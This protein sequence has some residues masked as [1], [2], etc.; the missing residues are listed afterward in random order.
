[1]RNDDTCSQQLPTWTPGPPR[2]RQGPWYPCRDPL[3]RFDP[4]ALQ[5]SIHFMQ[6]SLYS[7]GPTLAYVPGK[8]PCLK[9]PPE[10]LTNLTLDI[11]VFRKGVKDSSMDWQ[12]KLELS[13]DESKAVQP[14][15][16]QTTPCAAPRPWP[17]IAG[18]TRLSR[19][20]AT[21]ASPTQ[22]ISV[23][24]HSIQWELTDHDSKAVQARA[25]HAIQ[26]NDPRCILAVAKHPWSDPVAQARAEVNQHNGTQIPTWP[27]RIVE[28]DSS[29]PHWTACHAGSPCPGVSRPRTLGVLHG[30]RGFRP[31]DVATV[32]TAIPVNSIEARTCTYNDETGSQLLPTW[33]KGPPRC[34][35]GSWYP[36][37]GPMWGFDPC[38][39]QSGIPFTQVS[40][41]ASAPTL[42]YGPGKYSSLKMPPETSSDLTFNV[43]TIPTNDQRC[44]LA[45]ARHRWSDPAVQ[46]SA[47]VSQPNDTQTRT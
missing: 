40:L 27:S 2:Y 8:Y 21:S 34:I 29:Q 28:T 38:A 47:Q 18:S 9:M 6:M 43:Q 5:P 35:Q 42:A 4:R 32:S 33:A 41:D 30:R 45:E 3:C 23:S 20:T 24:S 44:V 13:D 19:P 25:V 31:A 39:V 16:V 10:T 14:A 15:A 22:H 11:P 37:R 12:K 26:S 1:M 17:T 7:G 46:A 36:C